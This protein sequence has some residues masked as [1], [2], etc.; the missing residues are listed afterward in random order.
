MLVTDARVQVAG[1]VVWRQGA[2]AVS[3]R[4][5]RSPGCPRFVLCVGGGVR[6]GDYEWRSQTSDPLVRAGTSETNVGRPYSGQKYTSSWGQGLW[7]RTN[8]AA[9]AGISTACNS[10]ERLAG[11]NGVWA[12]LRCMV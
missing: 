7:Q 8:R 5:Q 12:A 4:G 3:Q 2:V 1:W 6:V 9:L 11:G 10:R